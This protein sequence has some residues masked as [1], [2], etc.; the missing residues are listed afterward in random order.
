LEQGQADRR[1]TFAAAEARLVD[2]TKLQIEVD[3]RIRDLALFDLTLLP[4]WAT[5]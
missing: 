4:W 2:P 5:R 1:Q 3:R